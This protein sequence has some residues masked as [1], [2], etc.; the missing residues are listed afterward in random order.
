[1]DSVKHDWIQYGI[2]GIRLRNEKQDSSFAIIMDERMLKSE[3]SYNSTT[4]IVL[5]EGEKVKVLERSIIKS[6]EF[7]GRGVG[8]IYDKIEHITS[9]SVGYIKRA[10]DNFP[11][12]I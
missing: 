10:G 6:D 5:A 12:Y 1:M 11:S 8:A 2:D 4:I 3:P 9:G 7:G